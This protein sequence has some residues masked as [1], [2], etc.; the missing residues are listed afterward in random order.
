MA[1]KNISDLIWKRHQNHWN[2]IM[3]LGSLCVLFMALWT[4]SVFLGLAFI[5]GVGASMMELPE[6]TPPFALIDKVL[7][8]E[9]NWLES[10]WG[11]KKGLQG[12]GMSA[13]VVYVFFACWLESLMALLLLIGIY[14]NIACV[15]GN[16]RMGIDDL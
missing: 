5:A 13:S 16:K 8:H 15:Y 2:W 9:R 12:F 6:P 7:K 3:M 4:K 10:P 14:A 1:L 11:W